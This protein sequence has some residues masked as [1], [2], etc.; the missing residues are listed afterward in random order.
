VNA[1]GGTANEL[2]SSSDAAVPQLIAEVAKATKWDLIPIPDR[3]ESNPTLVNGA[4]IA[5]TMPSH[6][7]ID[8]EAVF[9][10]LP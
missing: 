8:L 2:F 5:A 7:Q 4:W 9:V 3:F 1:G 10:V 6:I